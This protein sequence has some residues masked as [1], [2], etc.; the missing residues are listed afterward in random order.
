MGFKSLHYMKKME[1]QE[2]DQ[3]VRFECVKLGNKLRVRVI[4]QGYNPRANCQF[5]RAIR[6]Q[7]RLYTAPASAVTFS[8]GGRG[9]LFYR[10]PAK[11]VT[12]IRDGAK[13]DEMIKDLELFEEED[14]VCCL[15]VKPGVVF[16]PCGH[17]C[18][19]ENCLEQLPKQ[20]CPMCRADIVDTASREEA[21]A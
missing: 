8:R 11:A 1:T 3:E 16:L 10:V 12:I 6:A 21:E 18:L 19:C 4:S 13:R 14:C 15:S 5:P 2:E 7:G 20:T 17:F 9:T